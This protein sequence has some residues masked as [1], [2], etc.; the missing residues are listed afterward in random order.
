MNT[1]REHFEELKKLSLF[2]SKVISDSMEPII[3]IGEEVV[4]DVGNMDIKRFDIIVIY[5]DGKLVCHYLWKMNRYLKPILLQT[6]NMAG[7]LD[8]PVYTEDYL[9]KV[10]SHRL[11][12][13]QKLRIIF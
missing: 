6:R 11:S 12:L 1:S 5:N 9:G 4:I 2:K 3:K 8:Y 7:K 10:L 13:W